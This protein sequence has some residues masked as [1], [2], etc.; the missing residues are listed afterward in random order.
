[1]VSTFGL[2]LAVALSATSSSKLGVYVEGTGDTDAVVEVAQACPKVMLW[3]SNV[4][5][6]SSGFSTYTSN[7]SSSSKLYLRHPMSWS[8]SVATGANAS[9]IEFA[10]RVAQA[11][12]KLALPKGDR[13]LD[14]AVEE[15]LPFRWEDE[16]ESR[17]WVQEYVIQLAISLEAHGYHLLLPLPAGKGAYFEVLKGLDARLEG[18]SK[19][20]FVAETLPKELSSDLSMESTALAPVKMLDAFNAEVF[21]K[22]ELL[23]YGGFPWRSAQSAEEYLGWLGKFD[24]L[25][26]QHATVLGLA[27][28]G[29]G[30][31][32]LYNLA[33]LSSELV[34]LIKG[35]G[36]GGEL[37]GEEHGV[38]PG[39][40]PNGDGISVER[41]SGCSSVAAS[42]GSMWLCLAALPLLRRRPRAS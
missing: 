26:L 18:I 30:T 34:E 32:N 3:E 11:L 40:S 7:C 6:G 19:W 21:T 41:G 33:E 15:S 42:F 12:S 23:L 14:I 22:R 35:G 8:T 37:P 13:W 25:L 20:A 39:G 24:A 28:Q 16:T 2:M 31:A 10:E 1:M 27:V 36:S 9:A 38:V 29:L 17:L 4:V 5:A